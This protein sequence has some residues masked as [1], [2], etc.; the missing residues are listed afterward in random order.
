MPALDFKRRHT[1]ISHKPRKRQ[2]KDKDH[3]AVRNKSTK[4]VGL[5]A[6]PWN[7]ARLPDMVDDAEGF[8]GLEEV[9][10]VEVVKDENLGRVEYRVGEA[11]LNFCPSLMIG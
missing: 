5:D 4:S 1:D 6:L 8:F 11:S 9:S 2:R 10:D 3:L 7:E